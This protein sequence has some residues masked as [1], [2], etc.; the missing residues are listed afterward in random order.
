MPQ[1]Y[2]D[3]LVDRQLG[4]SGFSRELHQAIRDTRAAV[5]GAG[6][7]G[8]V[9]DLLVRAG[10]MRFVIIDGDRV[11]ATNLNRLPF[12]QQ[13]VG[14]PKTE[15]WKRH[16]L[17]INP[18]CDIALHTRYIKG[19]S[20]AWLREA[21]QGV[22]LVFL[23][24]TDVEANIVAGRLCAQAGIRMIV[25]PASSGSLIVSTFRHDDGLT[26][27]KMG[28][29][30]TEGTPL[31]DID[32]PALREIYARALTFP[33]RKKNLEEETWNAVLQGRMPARSCGFF[34]RLTNAAMAFEAVKNVAE[35]HGLPLK[36]TR[37]T[38]MPL[39]QIFDPW[40][41]G[42]YVFDA[43]SARVGVPDPI[44][45]EICWKEHPL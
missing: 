45:G 35:M 37:V 24:A 3:A 15:A 18:E 7:N 4:F 22:H 30:G 5:I 21:L 32:Y 6:G 25:G 36:N 34:V 29:F 39:V 1:S 19:D 27:E 23:G 44:S 38:A 14:M 16:L 43:A 12:D 31:E 40:T 26:V 2:W 11:E 9:L 17:A 20:A 10:F 41:G 33:G 8:A 13:S 28:C 42:A